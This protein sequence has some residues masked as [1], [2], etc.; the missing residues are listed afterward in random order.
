VESLACGSDGAGAR[1]CYSRAVNG[2]PLARF[3]DRTTRQAFGDLA[4]DDAPAARY[5]TDLLTRFARA[6]ALR[7]ADL[8]PGIRLDNVVEALLH[9]E[10]SWEWS[11][12]PLAPP[13]E[14][15]VRQHIGDYTLF[16]TGIF[17]D[18][19]ERLAVAGY[20]RHEGRRA[21]RF[22]AETAHG[23]ASAEA[24]LFRRLADRF[25]QY[26]GALTYM[27]KVYFRQDRLP[28]EV[29]REPFRWQLTLG[30]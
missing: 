10:R 18:H 11:A 4:L 24:A 23:G 19:V 2:G 15:R 14:R 7:G 1:V 6:D 13:P 17:A 26:A 9:I 12:P 5:V 25:E 30:A 3:F 21:Y 27:R 22:L 20:Y 16:M 29:G 8:L 28:P